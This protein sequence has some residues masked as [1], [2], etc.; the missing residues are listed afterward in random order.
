MARKITAGI[1]VALSSIFLGLS[2]AG[3]IMVW[4]YKEPFTQACIGGLQRVDSEL[5]LIQTV[6]QTAQSQLE[7]A[8]QFIESTEKALAGL[9]ING[10]LDQQRVPDLK[11]SQERINLAKSTLLSLRNTL[12]QIN[13]L[14]ILSLSPPTKTALENLIASTAT[15]DTEITRVEELIQKASTFISDSSALLG[16][17]Y[18]ATKQNLQNFLQTI[19]TYDQ[20][21]SGWRA[22]VAW[23][24]RAVPGWVN[25]A[26]I[27]LT[28]FLIWF[29]FSQFGLVRQELT[30]LRGDHPLG[31]LLRKEALDDY[32]I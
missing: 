7:R 1:L 26:C 19:K 13:S 14:T 21:I 12:E 8:L 4:T 27:S 24:L 30:I 3:I 5:A 15:L 9:N 6:L 17:N 20:K 31:E 32:E 2:L 16:K 25:F 29:G 22:Q 10:A 23:L 18:T 11:S 28:V